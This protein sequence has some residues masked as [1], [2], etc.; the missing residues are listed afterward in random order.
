MQLGSGLRVRLI[1][2]SLCHSEKNVV[3]RSSYGSN[4]NGYEVTLQKWNGFSL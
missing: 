3:R 1:C 2:G 4:K